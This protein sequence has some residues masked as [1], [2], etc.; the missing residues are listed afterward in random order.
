ML[1]TLSLKNFVLIDSLNVEFTHGFNVLTGETGAGKSI[2]ID[3][4]SLLLGA[5]GGPE[6]VQSGQ[7]KAIIDGVFLLKDTEHVLSVAQEMGIDIED[8]ELFLS[9]E[10]YANG[11]SVCRINGRPM[12]VSCLRTIGDAM[13][14]IHGQNLN[15]G[16]TE[17]ASQREMIDA[18]AGQESIDLKKKVREVFLSIEKLRDN[19]RLLGGEEASRIKEQENLSYLITEI[20]QLDL[21]EDEEERLSEERARLAGGDKIVKALATA[22]EMLNDNAEGFDALTLVGK[23][24]RQIET[25][26]NLD[27]C[28]SKIWGILQEAQDSLSEAYRETSDYLDNF[29]HSPDELDKIENRLFSI[30]RLKAK[31]G[32]DVPAILGTCEAARC[33]LDELSHANERIQEIEQ[34]ILDQQKA[35]ATYAQQLSVLRHKTGAVM[36]NRVMAELAFVEMSKAKVRIKIEEEAPGLTGIDR[37]Q[38]LVSANP[39][40]EPK[41]LAKVASGG[42]LS[43]IMLALKTILSEVD[44][45]PTLIFD[46]IDAGIGGRTAHSVGERLDNL[47]AGRQVICVTHSPQIAALADHHLCIEKETSAERTMIMVRGISGAERVQEIAR[48]L[49]GKSI[50]EATLLQARELIGRK[51]V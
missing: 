30:G 5:R 3:A 27:E 1:N 10:I 4:I 41:P 26:H 20:E 43:R 35:Y 16:F 50:T 2:L 48:M 18:L 32:L 17:A 28:F 11:R 21:K 33:R 36:E 37:I 34:D 44:K 7:E 29:E 47:G 25:I 8:G 49:A 22:M 15:Q 40:E 14:D 6:F 24:S 38:F 12:N 13:V 31:L 51:G 45:M 19:I 46:E 9:R 23:A 42:E 39:G